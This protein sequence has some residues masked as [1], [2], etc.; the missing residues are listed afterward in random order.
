[1]NR[2]LIG[3]Q[4]KWLRHICP[5]EDGW[6]D[7]SGIKVRP[8]EGLG[9]IDYLSHNP[10]TMVRTA[11]VINSRV[12]HQFEIDMTQK[13]TYVWAFVIRALI[14]LGYDRKNLIAAPYDWRVPPP[15]LESRDGFFS[16]LKADVEVGM[17]CSPSSS[18]FPLT[19]HILTASSLHASSPPFRRMF[20]SWLRFWGLAHVL[21]AGETACKKNGERV[22]LIGH[23]MGNR[24]V[25]RFLWWL[26]QTDPDFIKKN[27]HAYMALGAPLLGATKV[28]RSFVRPRACCALLGLW[29]QSRADDWRCTWVGH[30]P[31]SQRRSARRAPSGLV[32]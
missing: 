14:D 21:I 20:S 9:A 28:I 5:S 12:I 26:Q 3:A 29:A 4:R 17:C 8:C 13:P 7:P 18:F 6:S 22:V 30:V 10:L 16:K 24:N 19:P 23:S 32:A 2:C 15:V 11:R 25:Q 27:I 1:M 31:G